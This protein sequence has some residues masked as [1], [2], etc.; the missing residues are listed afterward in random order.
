M[1]GGTFSEKIFL[2]FYELILARC[3]DEGGSQKTGKNIVF[4]I[5]YTKIRYKVIKWPTT[6]DTSFPFYT[7]FFVW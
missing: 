5:F 6:G 2:Y 4:I 1:V 7:Q 3:N